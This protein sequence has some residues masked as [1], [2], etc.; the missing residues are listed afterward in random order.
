[1]KS[2]IVKFSTLGAVLLCALLFTGC[3]YNTMVSQ[4]E[5]VDGQWAN[6]ESQYQRRSDLIPN[7]VNTVQGYAQHEASVLTAVT[8]ARTQ[9]A[10]ITVDTDDP[11][12]FEKYVEAQS[13][14][15]S[16]L[17]R[18]LA[19]AEAYPDLK[20][21]ENFL[22][23][24]SQLEGT[25]NRIATE[26]NRY[27]EVVRT[28]NTTIQKFP[29]LIT[30]KI[31]G[32]K[33]KA[34]FKA[35]PTAAAAPVVQFQS[36]K[37]RTFVRKLSLGQDDL[38]QIK[39]A[40]QEAEAK[41]SGE[42]ALAIIP[43]SASYAFWEL[44]MALVTSILLLTAVFPL[45]DSVY[46]W[47]SSVAWGER[48]WYLVAFYLLLC[49]VSVG[50]LYVA[51]NIPFIDSLIVPQRAKDHAVYARA[52]RYFTESGVYA[53]TSHSGILIFVSYF[54]HQVRIVADRG[55]SQK[56]S[57][58]LWNLIADEMAEQ[59]AKKN[60]KEAFLGAVT[61]AGDLLAEY[62]PSQG[63]KQNELSDG[64]VILENDVWA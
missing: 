59:L 51:Y 19:V 5:A 4:R 10:S 13:Q 31:F 40:V 56:I 42:I 45:A 62:F 55:I 20:A 58:D 44:L 49:A 1:M 23:L 27:N 38:E 11:E 47:L 17:S 28:Y 22:D 6:V 50:L 33:E 54:E 8:N 14:L 53:T 15:S 52:M 32:F 9:A 63:Q 41:T 2:S 39:H 21:N 60:V 34:Y 64:L 46:A 16:S 43:E 18:L 12:A 57:Q 35:E 26:R 29:G 7:L 36:M 30:A 61:R 37:Y 25:E 48:P 3:G 24:Q